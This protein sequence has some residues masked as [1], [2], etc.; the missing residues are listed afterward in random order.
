MTCYIIKINVNWMNIFWIKIHQY[1]YEIIK[2]IFM[3]TNPF[4]WFYS[5]QQKSLQT[6]LSTTL[7]PMKCED[8][9]TGNLIHL[10]N[11]THLFNKRQGVIYCSRT[12]WNIY[13]SQLMAPVGQAL[14]PNTRLILTFTQFFTL[15]LY[16][17][18]C[19]SRYKN[20]LKNPED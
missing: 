11:S 18:C 15:H 1:Y 10:I 7:S 6:T 3:N 9:Q 13:Y 20:L 14:L 17:Y 16:L 4:I 8:S 2:S 5:L 12:R 19:I